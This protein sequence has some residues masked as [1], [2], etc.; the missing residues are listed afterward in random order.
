MSNYTVFEE[1]Q[2]YTQYFAYNLLN[3]SPA[4][5]D[6]FFQILTDNIDLYQALN[7]NSTEWTLLHYVK[8]GEILADDDP[9]V[10]QAY[11]QWKASKGA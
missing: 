2:S 7:G 10:I 1:Y 8:T 6:R 11:I 3:L 4:D 9:P 5:Q